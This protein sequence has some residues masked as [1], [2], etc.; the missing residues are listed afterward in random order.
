MKNYRRKTSVQRTRNPYAHSQACPWRTRLHA[1]KERA[2]RAHRHA[3]GKGGACAE[4][5]QP[6]PPARLHAM[7]LH[8]ISVR[9]RCCV[10]LHSLTQ[11]RT[12]PRA[13]TPRA[14]PYASS[15]THKS[16]PVYSSSNTCSAVEAH[17]L[18]PPQQRSFKS[19]PEACGA[20]T[21]VQVS[22]N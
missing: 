12:L 5:A 11:A 20:R 2:T 16:M 18:C 1:R 10:H 3:C 6:H 7:R 17:A 9:Q 4:N 15:N 14:P 22:A 13:P 19:T 8:V 21:N